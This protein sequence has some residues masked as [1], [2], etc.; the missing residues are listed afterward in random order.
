MVCHEKL[1]RWNVY[2]Y[3]YILKP[4]TSCVYMFHHP[5]LTY[6][7]LF[8]LIMYELCHEYPP[9]GHERNNNNIII[10]MSFHIQIK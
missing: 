4:D 1:T 5:V 10:N 7:W 3:S 6:I 8:G 2:S 9:R